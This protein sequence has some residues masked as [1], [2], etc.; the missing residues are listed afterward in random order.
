MNKYH[1]IDTYMCISMPVET[2]PVRAPKSETVLCDNG[3]ADGAAAGHWLH[4]ND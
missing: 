2:V 3:A 4:A 1:F